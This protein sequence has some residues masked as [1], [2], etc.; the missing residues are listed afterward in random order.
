MSGPLSEPYKPQIA[1]TTLQEQDRATKLA[2]RRAKIS[3]LRTRLANIEPDDT[4]NA[5][6]DMIALIGINK[7]ILD[8]LAADAEEALTEG[9]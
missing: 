7:G 5:G 2:Q 6:L 9:K 3:R 4:T 1:G 8:V